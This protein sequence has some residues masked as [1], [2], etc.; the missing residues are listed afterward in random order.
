MKKY[1]KKI[2]V[3]IDILNIYEYGISKQCICKTK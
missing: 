3:D 1:E 2:L